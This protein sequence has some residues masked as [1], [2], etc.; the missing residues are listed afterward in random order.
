MVLDAHEAAERLGQ[1]DVDV[2]IIDL[3]SLNPLDIDTVIESVQKTHR[4]VI[5]HEATTTAGFGAEIAAQVVEH[6]LPFL[7]HAPVRVGAAFSPIPFSPKLERAFLPDV[8][9]IV[10]AV[11]RSMWL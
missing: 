10:N 4:I 1:D 7:D 2:E 6:A 3:R 9:D 5:A 11:K 8:D